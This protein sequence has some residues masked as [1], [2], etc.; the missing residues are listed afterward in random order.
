[1]T[2]SSPTARI[3][4]VGAD[5]DMLSL[6]A[7]LLKEEGLHIL[8][9]IPPAGFTDVIDD[10]GAEIVLI[11][12][13]DEDDAYATIAEALEEM[14]P[15]DRPRV[16]ILS[17]D[18]RGER[19]SKVLDDGVDDYLSKPFDPLELGARLRR[20]SRSHDSNLVLTGHLEYL[21]LSDLLMTLHQNKKTGQ[22][23][24]Y[25]PDGRYRYDFH[26]GEIVRVQGPRGL[27]GQKAFFRAMR[28]P[29]GTFDFA[30]MNISSRSAAFDNLA[31]TILLAVQEADEFPLTRQKLPE[32]PVAVR[33]TENADDVKLEKK[34]VLQPLM[35]GLIQSTTIDIL[36]HACPKTDLAAAK[37]LES[38]ISKGVLEVAQ[39]A[40][41]PVLDAG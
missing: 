11:D 36:I 2:K 1:M 13:V 32:D 22:L 33:L 4:L 16:V 7:E 10:A 9:E 30:P 26:K 20:L 35:E 3:L 31:N 34:T 40:D 8:S 41:L 29:T 23:R 19:I 38:L 12:E 6:L 17:D 39:G 18:V 37:E 27:K 28:E 21:G 5:Q 25:V 14:D 15:L 24:A